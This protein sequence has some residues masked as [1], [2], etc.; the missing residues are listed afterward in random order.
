MNGAPLGARAENLLMIEAAINESVSKELNPHVPYGLDEVVQA[1][2]ECSQAG[3]S[4]IHF[5]PRQAITGSQYWTDTEFYRDAFAL[6]RRET[7][8]ILYPTQQPGGLGRV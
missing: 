1:A 7:D 3:A 4:I 6:I 5:H 8:A 2:V